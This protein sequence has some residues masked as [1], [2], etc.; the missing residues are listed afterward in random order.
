MIFD[1]FE[2]NIINNV[3]DFLL[4]CPEFNFSPSKDRS[5]LTPYRL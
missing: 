4:L 2:H 5:I 1:H 3:V